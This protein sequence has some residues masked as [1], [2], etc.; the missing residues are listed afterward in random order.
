MLPCETIICYEDTQYSVSYLVTSTVG[1]TL[2]EL[3][4]DAMGL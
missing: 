3:L 2:K 4:G 1:Q